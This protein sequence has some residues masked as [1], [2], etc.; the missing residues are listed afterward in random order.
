M[1]FDPQLWF[2]DRFME[3]IP[4]HFTYTSTPITKESQLWIT[5]TLV[6]RY[7]LAAASSARPYGQQHIWE[8]LDVPCFEDAKEAILY[9][10]RWSGN[11]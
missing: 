7:G 9:E 1:K 3:I 6:G 4:K 8:N 11:N 2:K 5:T 10:L